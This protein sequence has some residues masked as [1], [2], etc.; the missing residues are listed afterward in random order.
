MRLVT[1]EVRN[2]RRELLGTLL[3]DRIPSYAH[4]CGDR[5]KFV[6]QR[7]PKLHFDVAPHTAVLKTEHL[8]LEYT[9][10]RG[11]QPSPIPQLVVIEG[12]LA[13]LRQ[14]GT[15]RRLRR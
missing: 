13:K 1:Y 11:L 10:V 15:L 5:I 9:E 3:T 6:V 8:V 7:Q 2:S 12:S 14:L 4:R